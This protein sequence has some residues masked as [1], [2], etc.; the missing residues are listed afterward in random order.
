MNR[1]AKIGD[2]VMDNVIY[3][4]LLVI[5]FVAMLTFVN[6]KMNGAVIWEDYYA[7][8]IAQI[9]DMSKPGDIITLDVQSATEIAYK[10]KIADFEEIFLFDNF[11]NEVCVK[12]SRGKASCFSYFSNVDVKMARGESNWIFFMEP[13]NRLHFEIV[14]SVD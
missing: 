2:I 6:S 9:I 7:K 10:N 5:F 4:I 1:K 13:V 12:L 11:N 8:E 14:E 3:L